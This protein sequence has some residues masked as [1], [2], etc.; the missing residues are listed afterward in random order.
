MADEAATRVGAVL[1][2]LGA[3]FDL[4]LEAV[5]G[6]G[7][8]LDALREEIVGQFT[9]V[10]RQIRFLSDRIGENRESI[11]TAR[12]DLGAEMVRLGETLGATRVEFREHLASMRHEFGQE[13]ARQAQAAHDRAATELARTVTEVESHLS[14]ELSAGNDTL[15]KEMAAARVELG[16]ELPAAAKEVRAGISSSADAIVKKIDAEL[17]QT[18][19]SLA[20]LARKFERFDDRIT[21][22]TKDQDQ[23]MRKLERRAQQR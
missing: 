5:S 21:V 10:G 4:V 8:R 16:R 12:A 7:G 9:E 1:E 11:G 22:Q 20:N 19:K 6:F 2:Q 15:R 13:M 23:R 18:N 17:K 14:H 3:R